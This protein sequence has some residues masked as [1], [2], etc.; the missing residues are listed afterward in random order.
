MSIKNSISSID[1]RDNIDSPSNATE[2]LNI[3]SNINNKENINNNKIS[4]ESSS[5][6]IILNDDNPNGTEVL[7]LE[8]ST[9]NDN[10]DK[11][12]EVLKINNIYFDEPTPIDK[13]PIKITELETILNNPEK[14]I[15]SMTPVEEKLWV[16]EESTDR[17]IYKTVKYVPAF[18]RIFDELLLTVGENFYSNLK[19]YK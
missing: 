6:T 3:I 1:L 10:K 11:E 17:F 7:I 9:K 8:D 18:I 14:W 5:K 13:V 12:K 16:F 19:F 2:K 4:S 15:G